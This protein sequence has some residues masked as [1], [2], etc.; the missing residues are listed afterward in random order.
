MPRCTLFFL[1]LPLSACHPPMVPTARSDASSPAPFSREMVDDPRLEDRLVQDDA[2]LVVYYGSEH[3]GTMETCGCPG[4][5]HG[6][7]PRLQGWI[8]ASRAANPGIPTL[9][10]HGGWFLEDSIG[11]GGGLRQDVPTMNRWMMV[12]L[13]AM[14]WDA[15][16]VAWPDLPGL[17]NLGTPFP[18]LPL[19]SANVSGPVDLPRIQPF[20][21]VE[22][23][24]MRVGIVGITAK[25]TSFLAD[26]RYKVK[27][28]VASAER[29][30][31]D[32]EGQVDWV[33]LLAYDAVD[34]SR[35]LARAHP[36]IR[37]VVDAWQHRE[38]V[39]PFLVNQALWVRS[40][41]E[42]W[43]VGELRLWMDGGS[44]TRAL[45][46]KVDLDPVIPD[47]P[48]VQAIRSRAGAEIRAIQKEMY[49]F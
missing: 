30:L 16:N 45:D 11:A 35:T 26:P 29:V 23:A 13:A 18:E 19:T 12:G 14:S 10:L 24:G 15:I 21:K 44:I 41:Y 2:D 36:Q 7:L 49:G 8:E 48:E 25:G 4:E 28:P 27:D 3:R 31:Q 34:A 40:W 33:V 6:S 39:D 22:R 17:E 38:S 43:R 20:L 47:D 1:L 37:L 32:L 9:T 5:T 46:R 42:T